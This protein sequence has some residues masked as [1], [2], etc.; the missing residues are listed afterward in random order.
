MFKA[1]YAY[2]LQDVPIF[3]SEPCEFVIKPFNFFDRQPSMDI[4]DVDNFEACIPHYGS[5]SALSEP[6]VSQPPPTREQITNLSLKADGLAPPLHRPR[7]ALGSKLSAPSNPT[8]FLG[9]GPLLAPGLAGDSEHTLGSSIDAL[10]AV[11]PG[12]TNLTGT[13]LPKSFETEGTTKQLPGVDSPQR[14]LDLGS[15]NLHAPAAS[16]SADVLPAF[17]LSKSVTA[18]STGGFPTDNKLMSPESTASNPSSMSD[19]LDSTKNADD[20][21]AERAEDAQDTLL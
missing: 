19:L 18:S 14:L 8:Y 15:A 3:F 7:P 16:P 11:A 17:Q 20:V 1:I 10:E 6:P 21:L 2:W 12:T 13:Q 4:V 5:T 9:G